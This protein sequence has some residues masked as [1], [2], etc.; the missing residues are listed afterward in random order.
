M[1]YFVLKTYFFFLKRTLKHLKISIKKNLCEQSSYLEFTKF[2][3]ITSNNNTLSLTDNL[4][5][6]T[7]QKVKFGF[8]IETFEKTL[9]K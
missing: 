7:S 1:F 9:E 5:T 8:S 6:I 3:Q 4:K 2:I